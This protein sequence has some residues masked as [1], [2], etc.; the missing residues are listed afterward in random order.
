VGENEHLEAVLAA[1]HA[2]RARRLDDEIA[3]LHPL[4]SG[5][6]G[7]AGI[8]HRHEVKLGPR[9]R[10]DFLTDAGVAVEVKKSRPRRADLMRQLEKYAAHDAISA[11]VLVLERSVPLPDTIG[12]KPVRSVSLNMLWGPAV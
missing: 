10:V 2:I 1:L 4:V 12:G 8:G 3:Y 11:I 6:L 5:A 7:N 9:S